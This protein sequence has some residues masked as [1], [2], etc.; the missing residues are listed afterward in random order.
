MKAGE[1]AERAFLRRLARGIQAVAAGAE[2]SLP[3]EGE[4]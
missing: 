3:D 2:G 1:R 4:S